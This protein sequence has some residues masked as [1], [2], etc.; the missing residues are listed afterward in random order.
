MPLR[1]LTR[2]LAIV[3]WLPCAAALSADDAKR[4]APADGAPI[5]SGTYRRLHS[6]VLGEDRLLRVRLPE[7]YENGERKYPVLYVLDGDR[8]VFA[9]ASAAVDYLADM[10]DKVPDHVVVGIENTDRRRDMD[11]EVGASVFGRFLTTELVPFVEANY[12]ANGFRILA[13]QSF[14]ALF[15]LHLF[16]RTPT[17]F[18][19]YILASPGLYKE[20]LVP[21]FER[22]IQGP[23]GLA[24]IGANLGKRRVLVAIGKLD[25]YDPDGSITARGNRFVE[26]LQRVAGAGVAVKTLTYQDEGHVPYPAVYDGL[27]WIYRREPTAPESRAPTPAEAR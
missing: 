2:C 13:G 24:K 4:P 3:A 1:G 16:V 8:S 10:T 27:K 17:A 18:D 14:S 19:A 11:P 6:V 5:A 26:S 21:L 7:G 25:S 15:A 20:S 23:T 12:R 22:E 9:R